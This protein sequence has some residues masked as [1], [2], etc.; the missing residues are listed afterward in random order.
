MTGMLIGQLVQI[1]KNIVKDE[2]ILNLVMRTINIKM[3][4]LKGQNSPEI[5][6]E[7]DNIF[8]LINNVVQMGDDG[9]SIGFKNIPL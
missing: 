4:Y 2:R 7:L 5:V 6:K 1:D 9:A 3:E 8:K